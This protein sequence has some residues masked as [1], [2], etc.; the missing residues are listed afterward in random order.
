MAA[1]DLPMLQDLGRW[2]EGFVR[3]TVLIELA[4][5]AAC[6]G[7]AWL[8]V[9]ALQRG[10]HRGDPRSILFGARIVDGALFPLALLGLAYVSRTLLVLWFPLAVFKVA[11]PVL[12]S[13]VV[14]R[15]GVKVLQ[16]AYPDAAW[17]RPMERSIS[18]LA[19]LG[20]VLWVTGL[21]PLVL[22]ELD[23]IQWK[24]G[25]A[26]LSVR[27]LIEGALTAGAVLLI[28]LWISAAIEARLMR[29]ATGAELSLRKA[30]SN[31]VRALLIFVGLIMA[32]S[33]VGIDLTALSVL[34]GAV[35]VGIGFGLQKLA[36]NYVSGFVILAERSMRIG[37]N[38]RVDNFEGRITGINARYTVVRSPAGRESI[39]PNEMLIIQRVENLS[40]AD[41]RV[42]LSTVVSV[43]YD[44]DVDLVTRLLGESALVNPRVLRDPAPS[45]ALSAFGADGLEFTV[46]FW[47]ADPENGSLG[48]RSDINRA[49]LAA[50][51]AHK[52]EIPYPQ[53]VMHVQVEG[54]VPVAG[55]VVEQVASRAD[56]PPRQR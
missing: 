28:A 18:W 17:V 21:L 52:I 25:G 44:S 49:I 41:P 39:V 29:S 8:L 53:R 16:V 9:S 30:V 14:I 27:T 2:A 36:S 11:V 33:A 32:L 48:L 15:I 42:W 26:T 13:L 40:L 46:G 10:L 6:V 23:K 51:R 4:T 5:L 31:A 54:P 56:Q 34:G 19:W 38:V 20:M 3:P 43:G 12:V 35:G 47:I 45:V 55:A 1:T 22:D 24:V 50:L 7:L 37:D